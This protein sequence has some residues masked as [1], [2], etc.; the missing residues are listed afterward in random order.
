MKKEIAIKI[1]TSC[2]RD[3]HRYLENQNLLFLFGTLQ[4]TGFFEAAFLPRHFLHLTGVEVANGRFTGS[5][6][7]YEKALKGQLSPYDFSLSVTGT[8][9]MKLLVLPQLVRIY[10]TAKMVGDYSFTKSALYT[11][12]LAGNVTACLGFLREDEY[13]VPNTALKED[14]RDVSVKPQQRVLAILRKPVTQPIYREVCYRAKGLTIEGIHLPN[15]IQPKV[16][17]FECSTPV[18]SASQEQNGAAPACLS[19]KEIMEA[20]QTEAH[21]RNS[22]RAADHP[23]FSKHEHER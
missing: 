9:E 21:R 4:N 15:D 1:I 16:S 23:Q 22:T 11:E 10:H 3:Y 2:A 19:I 8:T 12:R 18:A 5:S 7:F 13:Y 6:D 20:T 14:I 17:L